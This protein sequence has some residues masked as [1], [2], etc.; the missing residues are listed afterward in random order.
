M[1]QILTQ[2]LILSKHRATL[3]QCIVTSRHRLS[4]VLSQ[5]FFGS[6]RRIIDTGNTE[7]EH[8]SGWQIHEHCF[9]QTM[10]EPILNYL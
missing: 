10:C 8:Q 6:K 1:P 4:F 2:C 9:L 7:T 5:V 3:K